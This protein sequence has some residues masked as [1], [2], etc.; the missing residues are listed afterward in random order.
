MVG[1]VPVIVRL[2]PE[3]ETVSAVFGAIWMV[4][5]AA[6]WVVEL[7]DC[8][9]AVDGLSAITAASVSAVETCG[10]DAAAVGPEVG[11]PSVATA[12]WELPEL[13]TVAPRVAPA[14]A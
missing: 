6:A 2:L 11:A 10:Q 14:G 12:T 8:D 4:W 3:H 5:V 13:F 9:V 7:V 1:P